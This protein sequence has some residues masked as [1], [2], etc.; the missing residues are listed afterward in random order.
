MSKS[1]GEPTN[2][3]EMKPKWQKEE[4]LV[5][6]LPYYNQLCKEA[7]YQLAAIKAGLGHSV[8]LRDVRPAL[9]HWVCELDR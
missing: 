1:V 8:L 6:K 5:K 7:D 3:A 2:E 4:K 9:L